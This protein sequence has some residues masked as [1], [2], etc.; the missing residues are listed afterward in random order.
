MNDDM[1]KPTGEPTH[2][3]EEGVRRPGAVDARETINRE[4]VDAANAAYSEHADAREGN[5]RYSANNPHLTEPY[6]SLET[7]AFQALRRYGDMHPGT[8]DGDVI[9]MFIEFANLVIEDLRAHPYWDAVYMDY[10]VHPTDIRP[11]PDPIMVAGLMYHYSMQ[12]S[13][14]KLEIYA[15]AYFRLTSRILFNRK[16]GNGPIEMSPVDRATGNRPAT[17]SYDAGRNG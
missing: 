14:Q 8:V 5:N 2:L 9:M 17:Q 10:Y 3:D 16:Y 13:S 12:Q 1:A 7:L 6:S 4:K 15:P 11:I